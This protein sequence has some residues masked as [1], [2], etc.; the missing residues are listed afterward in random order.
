MNTLDHDVAT[1][2]M[3]YKWLAFTD[4]DGR[5]CRDLVHP[6]EVQRLIAQARWSYAAGHEIDR[7]SIPHFST[8]DSL[9][10]NILT[11]LSHDHNCSFAVICAGEHYHVCVYP[12]AHKPGQYTS[13]RLPLAL[14]HA[15]LQALK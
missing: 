6:Q 8:D 4:P 3:G 13:L 10:M 5:E 9:V 1:V 2:V 12:P 11:A 15:A 14:C 7:S